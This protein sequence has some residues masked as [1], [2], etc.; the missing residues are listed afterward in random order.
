MASVS[1]SVAAGAS[2]AESS[3]RLA[4]WLLVGAVLGAAFLVACPTGQRSPGDQNLGAFSVTAR[5]AADAGDCPLQEFPDGGFSFAASFS[6]STASGESFVAVGS[7]VH[8][9]SLEGRRVVAAY[10]A[11][12]SFPECDSQDTELTERLEVVLL[13]RVQVDRLVAAGLEA[14]PEGLLENG[15]PLPDG[16]SEAVT[17]GPAGGTGL[18]A[19]R[20][21]GRLEN[22]V[23][24]GEGTS[25]PPCRMV[26]DLSGVPQ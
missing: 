14:C 7:Y 1:T 25:C 24:A 8:R 3:R 4:S 16:G 12:R 10:S 2:R 19:V 26:F 17:V 6:R 21:C 18:E 15:I 13:S 22:E 20:V 11:R 9:A 23:V 5:P